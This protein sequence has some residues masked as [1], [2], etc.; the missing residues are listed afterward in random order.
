MEPGLGGRG[1]LNSLYASTEIETNVFKMY[2]FWLSVKN[3]QTI[4]LYDTLKKSNCSNLTSNKL[5]KCLESNL[6]V[7]KLF[8]N[9]NFLFYVLARKDTE[10]FLGKA[11][12]LL[13]FV[14]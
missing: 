8:A 3:G 14:C 10:I 11:K 4:I 5:L 6:M 7:V 9:A 12:G 13:L 1:V 2:M